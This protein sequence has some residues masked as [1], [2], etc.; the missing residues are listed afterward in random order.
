MT[1]TIQSLEQ[2]HADLVSKA[3]ELAES[4]KREKAEQRVAALDEVKMLIEQ[5]GFV[6]GDLFDKAL[7]VTP[8]GP[9]KSQVKRFAAQKSPRT[10]FVAKYKDPATGKTWV[11][12]GKRPGWLVAGLAA[13]KVLADY[14]I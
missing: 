4:I 10:P 2:E 12:R 3:A 14:A 9:T 8:K 13:G 6:P 1:E 7:L 11:G 5:N